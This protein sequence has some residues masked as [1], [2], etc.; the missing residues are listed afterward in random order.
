[1]AAHHELVKGLPDEGFQDLFDAFQPRVRPNTEASPL[2]I[3]NTDVRHFR[4]NSAA[5][6]CLSTKKKNEAEETLN[7]AY[8]R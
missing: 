1:M 7:V 8:D 2:E 5:P 6:G 3:L 4:L